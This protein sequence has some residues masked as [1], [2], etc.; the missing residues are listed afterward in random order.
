MEIIFHSEHLINERASTS[1]GG[2]ATSSE[3]DEAPSHTSILGRRVPC[4]ASPDS[5][6]GHEM[7]NRLPPLTSPMRIAIVA[8]SLRIL[9]GQAVQARRLVEKWTRDPA[10]DAWLVPINP[11]PPWPLRW[12]LRVKYL[13]TIVTQL[14]YWPL[15]L[16]EL[17]RADIVHV[18]S[19]SYTSFLLA[20]TP[21]IVVAKLLGRAVVLNYHSG[22]APDHLRRSPFARLVLKRWVDMNVVPS[23]FLRDVLAS[24]GI[25]AVVAPNTIDPG[26]FG[27]RVRTALRPRLLSTRNLEPI[28][29][30]ADVLRAFALVQARHPDA[31]LTIVGDGSQADAL[32][33]LCSTLGL[34]RVMFAGRVPPDEIHRWYDDAD[35][36]VQA[37]SIDNMP[38]SVLEAFASGLPVVSTGVG[39]V[40]SMLI[41][42]EH[43]LL[44]PAGDSAALAAHIMALLDDPAF[45]RRLAAQARQACAAYEWPAVRDAWIS[46]YRAVLPERKGVSLLAGTNRVAVPSRRARTDGL[47]GRTIDPSLPVRVVDKMRRAD[48]LGPP[49][50]A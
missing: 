22:E 23:P 39:G 11:I 17:R 37:P 49:G 46:A 3:N 40:P 48:P 47:I 30:V 28:Y 1:V 10:V 4:F 45:A 21:A 41:D 31:S 19:A 20:P 16:R 38:L 12:L 24:F 36:Y 27:Y 6:N 26:E 14:V 35:I 33:A 13:R 8:A 5:P 25:S 44:A 50:A 7:R 42:G 9:G 34:H 18:F 2:H 15:L 43:G 29:N 32:R